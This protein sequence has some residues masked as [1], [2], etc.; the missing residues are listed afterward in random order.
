VKSVDR[1]SK[2]WPPMGSHGYWICGRVSPESQTSRWTYPG[3]KGIS[4]AIARTREGGGIGIGRRR[5]KKAISQ[6][7]HTGR[8]WRFPPQSELAAPQMRIRRKCRVAG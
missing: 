1:Q 4:S 3:R 6:S 7:P 2:L 8:T 5:S